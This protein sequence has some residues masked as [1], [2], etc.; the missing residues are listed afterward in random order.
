MFFFL[1]F[2]FISGYIINDCYGSQRKITENNR[3]KAEDSAV[4]KIHAAKLRRPA[5][6]SHIHKVLP[7][8]VDSMAEKVSIFSV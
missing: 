6:T 1:S 3:C 4:D 7:Q 8:G 5:F 2:G